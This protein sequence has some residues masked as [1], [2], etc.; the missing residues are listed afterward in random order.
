MGL[1]EFA[2]VFED[3]K[4]ASLAAESVVSLVA[5]LPRYDTGYWSR[6]CRAELPGRMIFI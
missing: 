2:D 1:R 4:A 3:E 5:A 6:Y